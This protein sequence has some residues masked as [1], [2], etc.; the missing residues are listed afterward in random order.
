MCTEVYMD[1][2]TDP[3]CKVTDD[4]AGM[5]NK[6]GVE[7]KDGILI[8]PT[9]IAAKFETEVLKDKVVLD[10]P[11]SSFVR[12]DTIFK[13]FDKDKRELLVQNFFQIEH[14]E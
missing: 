13:L 1:D 9:F 10:V 4:T 6:V 3:T 5:V 2:N 12:Q 14:I 11:S 7:K 8:Q